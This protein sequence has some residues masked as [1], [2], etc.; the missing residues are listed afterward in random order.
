MTKRP[1]KFILLLCLVLAEIVFLAAIDLPTRVERF[2]VGI[3]QR[4]T[5]R[6][7]MAWEREYSQI[8]TKNEAVRAAGM[9]EYI[10]NYYLPSP[11][12]YSDPGTEASLKAQRERSLATITAALQRFTGQDF[13]TDGGKWLEWLEAHDVPRRE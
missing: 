12:Y 10:K 6:E 2:G 3:H 9:L 1:R 8:E 13:G 5:T 4:G 7:L 11:G